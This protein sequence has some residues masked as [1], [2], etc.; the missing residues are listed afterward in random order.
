MTED[1]PELDEETRRIL[2]E[3][4]ATLDEDLKQ[5]VD[6]REFLTEMRRRLRERSR[7]AG[8][9]RRSDLSH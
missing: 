4:L 8:K 6:A 3:R 1:E 2:E 7:K 5:A 9:P